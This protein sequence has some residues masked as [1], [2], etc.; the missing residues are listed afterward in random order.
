M[1]HTVMKTVEAPRLHFIDVVGEIPVVVQRQI[2][3][4]DRFSCEFQ[5]G[6]G[7]YLWHG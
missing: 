3:M 1:V 7:D 4:Q 2:P 6:S 5:R